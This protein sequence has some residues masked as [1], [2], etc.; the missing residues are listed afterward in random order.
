VK[1]AQSIARNKKIYFLL[2]VFELSAFA[3]QAQYD[4]L[5][6]KTYGQR[7][8]DMYWRYQGGPAADSAETFR[9]ISGI[10]KTATENQDDDL[11]LESRLLAVH[12]YYYRKMPVTVA[13]AQ[14]LVEEGQRKNKA[15][16]IGRAE[17]VLAHFYVATRQYER[18]FVHFHRMYNAIKDL[19]PAEFPQKQNSLYLFANE[20]MQFKDYRSAIFFLR[21]ALK[22]STDHAGKIFHIHSIN[23]LG[24][25]YRELKELDSS[26]YY[27]N[28]LREWAIRSDN[29]RWVGISSGNLGYNYFLRKEYAKA[30]PMLQADADISIA[31]NEE[32]GLAAG[33]L[34]T[35]AEIS[36]EEK[37]IQTA[38]T[39]L[40]KAR[41]CAYR[42]GQYKRLNMLYPLLV[43][44]Y[45]AKGNTSLAKT[46]LDSAVVVRD[47]LDRQF[48]SLLM[49]RGKEKVELEQHQLAV[50]EVNRQK[51]VK[52]RQRN[53]LIVIIA[54]VT[55]VTLFIYDRQKLKYKQKNAQLAR[56]KEELEKATRELENFTRNISEKNKLI[57]DLQ[58]QL[59]NPDV[60]AVRQLQQSTILTD[61]QWADFRNL[62][63]K[64]HTGYL[65]RV[66]GKLPELTPAETRYV[67]LNKLK[68]SNKEMASMLGVGTDA[69]RQY[70]SRLRRKL[71]LDEESSIDELLEKI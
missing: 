18:A 2:L 64:V 17:D 60:E 12:Y 63:D 28:A 30:K 43:K 1:S 31:F 25:C 56:A 46:F 6:H 67:A 5:L 42:S 44:F 32:L 47:S 55:I 9:E 69:I 61:D 10:A 66:K 29:K 13:M 48:N 11:L 14:E 34:M 24:L 59:G 8:P 52:T 4:H 20:L 62:F 49:A 50:E 36:L 65:H 22:D 71:N 7:F 27:F 23:S 45:I 37:D 51:E 39:Q 38:E 41:E 19:T 3:L 26:S 33:A 16:L 40:M 54:V 35:L 21:I 70:R 53:W 57:E 68:L 15:W 58:Q